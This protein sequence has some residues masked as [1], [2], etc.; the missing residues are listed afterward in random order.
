MLASLRSCT[1][2]KQAQTEAE[3]KERA[4]CKGPYHN[5]ARSSKYRSKLKLLHCKATL[6]HTIAHY[7]LSL[8][9][10]HF[11]SP[12]NATHASRSPSPSR[13][14]SFTASLARRSSSLSMPA[15]D[16][17]QRKTVSCPELE[18]AFLKVSSALLS[19]ASLPLPLFTHQART[20][21]HPPCAAPSSRHAM[22]CQVSHVTSSRHYCLSCPTHSSRHDALLS[23]LLLQASCS[24]RF[25]CRASAFK[26]IHC[27]TI[28]L[29]SQTY[30]CTSKH[31]IHFLAKT[32]VSRDT[33]NIMSLETS[34]G[35]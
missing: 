25:A 34:S 22:P 29:A 31:F 33:S 7:S 16:P 8:S 30:H 9:F 12:S 11:Y 3:A 23:L 1:A 13:Q 19:C 4:P 21:S 35:P 24:P 14:S 5:K 2:S 15:F 6:I 26:G 32:Y 17:A 27:Y 10:F 20:V 18:A 28:R